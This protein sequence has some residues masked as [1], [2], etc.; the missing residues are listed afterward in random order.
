MHVLAAWLALCV[1]NHALQAVRRPLRI[2]WPRRGT[3]AASRDELVGRQVTFSLLGSWSFDPKKPDQAPPKAVEALHEKRV[4]MEG[5]MAPL[6]PERRFTTFMLVGALPKKRDVLPPPNRAVWVQFD[7]PVNWYREQRVWVQGKL[8]LDANPK[9]GFLYRMDG[10]RL[11]P[12]KSEQPPPPSA[13][14]PR[15]AAAFDFDWLNGLAE[16]RLKWKPPPA[17][18]NLDGKLV[19]ASGKVVARDEGPPLTL[20]VA[21]SDSDS[22]EDE[23]EPPASMLG[24]FLP[25]ELYR[26][27]PE[28]VEKP[29]HIVLS[30]WLE[31]CTDPAKWRREPPVSLRFAVV[32]DIRGAPVGPIL[33]WWAELLLGLGVAAGFVRPLWIRRRCRKALEQGDMFGQEAAFL[34][35]V[36]SLRRGASAGVVTDVLGE[37]IARVS[38]AAAGMDDAD[39]AWL[40]AL[41]RIDQRPFLEPLRD[42]PADMRPGEGEVGQCGAWLGVK[43]GRIISRRSWGAA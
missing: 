12:P 43:D 16:Q 29:R 9:E 20:V 38:G 26:G 28:P 30:G 8:Y 41:D 18:L 35:F 1:V 24:R 11:V 17:L 27:L 40:Y 5:Y 42:A 25:V 13:W 33:P 19:V 31:C 32:G 34:A 15:A 21:P 23:K 4:I 7:E 6:V 36:N 39:E 3:E 2:A 22:E 14:N 37:P 10:E